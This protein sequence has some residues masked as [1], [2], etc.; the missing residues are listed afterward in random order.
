VR[1]LPDIVL[2]IVLL[3]TTLILVRNSNFKNGDE[4]YTIRQR[5]PTR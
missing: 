4:I 2:Q 3:E 1:H 5:L